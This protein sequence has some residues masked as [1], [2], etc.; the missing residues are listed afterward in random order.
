M[1]CCSVFP[2]NFFIIFSKIIFVHFF[3]KKGMHCAFLFFFFFFAFF[4]FFFPTFPLFFFQLSSSFFLHLFFFQNYFCWFY[5]LNIELVKN[6]ALQFFFLNTV[7]C[8]GVFPH[9]FSFLFF[10]FTKLYLSIFFYIE[11]IENLVL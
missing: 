8:C 10:Y 2:Y 11:L 9:S 7:D 5:F 1:N 4:S 3:L 6:F